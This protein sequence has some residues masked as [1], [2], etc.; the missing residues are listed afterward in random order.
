MAVI[1]KGK[2]ICGACGFKVRKRSVFCYNC[3]ESIPGKSAEP[4]D[5]IISENGN[6]PK[7]DSLEDSR[8]VKVAKSEAE[9][10]EADA[11]QTPVAVVRPYDK[12]RLRSAASMRRKV[13]VFN[14]KP[15]EVT[16]VERERSST[17]YIIVSILLAVISGTLLIIAFYLK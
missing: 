4:I 11:N 15:V 12:T 14:R 5:Q 6:S 2:S 16:W 13:E 17:A 10:L 3:G 9:S 7:I 8:G 1:V